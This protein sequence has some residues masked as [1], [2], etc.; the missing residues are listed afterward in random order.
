MQHK[1]SP[2]KNWQPNLNTCW[3]REACRT[4]LYPALSLSSVWL[5]QGQ[6]ELLI[7]GRTTRIQWGKSVLPGIG[8][9]Q[10]S[11][12]SWP[13]LLLP[14]CPTL[15]CLPP[16][17][18]CPKTLSTCLLPTPLRWPSSASTNSP[19]SIAHGNVGRL[20][21]ICMPANLPLGGMTVYRS[22]F[23]LLGHCKDCVHWIV[24]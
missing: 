22:T 18:P 11:A 21:Y 19:F 8:V 17:F 24:S 10:T 13:H 16:V 3:K 1:S 9:C 23:M 4:V 6:G 5:N 7:W 15:E 20:V 14:I 2:S 12:R